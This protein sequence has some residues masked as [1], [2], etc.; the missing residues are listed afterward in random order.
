MYEEVEK[1]LR[2]SES[3]LEELQCYKGAGR[4]IRE[5]I[6]TQNEECQ[7]RAWQAVIPLVEKLKRFYLFSV[8]LGK[9][10]PARVFR[11]VDDRLLSKKKNYSSE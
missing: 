6:S 9:L 7:L 11:F 5:A 8:E 3:I 2:R 1:V 4:E 10:S